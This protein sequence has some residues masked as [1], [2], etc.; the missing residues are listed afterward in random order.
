MEQRFLRYYEMAGRRQDGQAV[1]CP[2]MMNE[3][4][5]DTNDR[6]YA[7]INKITNMIWIDHVLNAGTLQKAWYLMLI[8]RMTGSGASYEDDHGFRNSI[9]PTL[10]PQDIYTMQD[11]LCEWKTPAFTSKGCQIPPFPKYEYMCAKNR[12]LTWIAREAYPLINE[13]W[14]FLLTGRKTHGEVLDFLVEYNAKRGWKKFWFQ[15]ALFVSD[16]S[17]YWPK[18]IDPDSPVHLGSGSL[19]LVKKMDGKPNEVMDRLVSA[20]GSNYKNIEH[21]LCDFGKYLKNEGYGRTTSSY[22]GII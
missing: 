17:D 7:G 13:L 1:E 18:W 15:Y 20:T 22:V 10:I 12:G 2:L 6:R 16:L 3:D 14:I 11:T 5:Y 21:T 9:V 19:K 4:L 8:H